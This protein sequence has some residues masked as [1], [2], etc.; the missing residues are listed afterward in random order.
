MRIS[1]PEEPQTTAS[2]DQID[3]LLA[4]ARSNR[5]DHALLTLMVDAVASMPEHM[6]IEQPADATTTH[7]QPMSGAAAIARASAHDA[8]DSVDPFLDRGEGGEGHG[9]IRVAQRPCDAFRRGETHGDQVTNT[10][11]V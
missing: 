10:V 8:P 9:W 3:H 2:D 5:R 4:S 11:S 1:I 7:G 6:F